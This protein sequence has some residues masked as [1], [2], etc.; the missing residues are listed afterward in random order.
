MEPASAISAISGV[1]GIFEKL[2]KMY[3]GH[4]EKLPGGTEKIE[5]ENLLREAKENLQVAKAQL[6]EALG[7]ILCRYHFPPGVMVRIGPGRNNQWQCIDCGRR[8]PSD[9]ELAEESSYDEFSA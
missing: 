4:S 7:H 9:S 3:K 1:I 6:G 8:K 2:W 5:S